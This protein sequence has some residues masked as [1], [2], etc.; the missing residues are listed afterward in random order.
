[1][2]DKEKARAKETIEGF[3]QFMRGMFNN[4]NLCVSEDMAEKF[5]IGEEFREKKEDDTEGG[6]T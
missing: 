6:T 1:M 3:T 4:P 2:D 5:D